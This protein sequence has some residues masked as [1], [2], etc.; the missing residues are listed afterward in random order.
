M[1]AATITSAKAMAAR[2]P[3][4]GRLGMMAPCKSGAKTFHMK[5]LKAT[6]MFH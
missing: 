4:M 2:T 3:R 1:A 6:V 5:R